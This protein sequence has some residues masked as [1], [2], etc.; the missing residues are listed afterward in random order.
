MKAA[1]QKAEEIVASDPA[2][3]VLL[4]Q[5]ENPANPAVHEKTTGPEIWEAT[6]GEIDVLIS[7]VGTGG[8]ITG[9]S[10]FIKNTCGKPITSVAVE[11]ESSNMIRAALKG[12]EPAHAPHKILGAL[13]PALSRRHSIS[14]SS[15]KSKRYRTKNRSPG[16]TRLMREEGILAGIFQRCGDGGRRARRESAAALRQDY[17]GDPAGFGRARYLSSIFVRGRI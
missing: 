1:L 5:F 14:A 16:R 9:I 10:R 7:G 6:N 3:Y 13:A 4:Q 11:P 12:E 2:H 8:T 17:R 15:I